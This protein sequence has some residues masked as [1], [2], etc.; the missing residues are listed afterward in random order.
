MTFLFPGAELGRSGS[1]GLKLK[2]EEVIEERELRRAG[3]SSRDGGE[4]AS[5]I[6]SSWRLLILLL[7]FGKKKSRLRV[8]CESV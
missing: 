3:W 6:F 8:S 2:V 7:S 4:D 5:S 1:W